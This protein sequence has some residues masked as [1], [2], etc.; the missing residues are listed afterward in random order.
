[1][2]ASVVRPHDQH[3]TQILAENEALARDLE[4]RDLLLVLRPPLL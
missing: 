4:G 3:R 1:M 2:T